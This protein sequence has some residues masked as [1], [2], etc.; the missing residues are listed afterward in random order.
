MF[1]SYLN[2]RLFFTFLALAM[3]GCT[4]VASAT[5]LQSDFGLECRLVPMQGTGAPDAAARPGWA[6]PLANPAGQ[7]SRRAIVYPR[8]V[9]SPQLYRYDCAPRSAGPVSVPRTRFSDQ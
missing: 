3:I 5:G 1:E 4:N 6:M 8:A 2:M 7:P 9:P